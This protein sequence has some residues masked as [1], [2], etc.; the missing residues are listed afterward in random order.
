MCQVRKIVKS[1][2]KGKCLHGAHTLFLTLAFCVLHFAFPKRSSRDHRGDA[3][4][5]PHREG[6]GGEEVALLCFDKLDEK[7]ETENEDEEEADEPSL[8]VEER[9]FKCES[10]K[11]EKDAKVEE[12]FIDLNGMARDGE[13]PIGRVSKLDSPREGGRGAKNFLVDEVADPDET[14]CKSGRDRDEVEKAKE[15]EARLRRAEAV[16]K[17]SEGKDDANSCAVAGEPPF[18]DTE[19]FPWVAQVILGVFVEEEVAKS[20]AN[21]GPQN[22][23][24]SKSVGDLGSPLFLISP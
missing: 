2:K 12:G 5:L 13:A 11:E 21:N 18:P 7:A 15:S 3:Q 1:L 10:P 8:V 16:A 20:S 17:K 19:N 14:S 9:F 22:H 6:A 23:I 4:P 24:E